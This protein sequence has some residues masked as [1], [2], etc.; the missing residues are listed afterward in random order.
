MSYMVEIVARL[1]HMAWDRHHYLSII[2][3]ASLF[4]NSY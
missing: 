4:K 3:R 1:T 2:A